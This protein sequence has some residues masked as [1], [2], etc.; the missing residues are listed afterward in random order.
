MTVMLVYLVLVMI[1]EVFAFLIGTVLD[2]MFPALSMILFMALFFGILAL[3]WP[4]SVRIT[5]KW[6]MGRTAQ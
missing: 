5:E 2:K 4:I 6:L 1:G 3:A